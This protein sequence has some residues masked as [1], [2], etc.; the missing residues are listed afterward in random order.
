MNAQAKI[1]VVDDT[2]A[3]VEL[4]TRMLAGAGYKAVTSTLDPR[5]VRALHEEHRYDLIVLDLQMPGMDGFEVMAA[6]SEIETEGYLPVL[7]ITAQPD[8]KLRALQ[9]GA[10]DFITKPFEIAEVIMRVQNMLEVRLLHLE[11][12]RK[13]DQLRK[14][15]DEL[16]SERKV[17]E[18]LALAIPP[19]SIAARLQVRPDVTVASY[20]DATVLIASLIG[21]AALAPAE[22]PARLAEIIDE[23]FA[24]F[25]D[26]A[27]ARGLRKV[28]TLGNTYMAVAGV[29]V[30]A[31]YHA[32]MAAQAALSMDKAVQRFNARTDRALQVR[33]G[34]ASG[35]VMAGIIGK[36]MYVDDV[37]G[38]AVDIAA[39][40]ES[41]GVAGRLQAS[42]RTRKMLGNGLQL[43]SRGAIELDGLG[44]VPTW[45]V[46]G[47][48]SVA[49]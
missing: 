31:P 40:M 48:L 36:R 2:P 44:E 6:L 16:V 19:A 41:H 25:D 37:W 9:A 15:Y 47:T 49:T 43:E 46:N 14:L 24:E 30:A 42:E 12:R 17:S 20:A 21:F 11:V 32:D 34:I 23:L 28:K 10:K 8:H 5:T 7:V 26:I 4:L 38:G 13:N 33:S 22:S 35:A 45:F 39:R 3:N 1:L 18:C 29:P 27:H